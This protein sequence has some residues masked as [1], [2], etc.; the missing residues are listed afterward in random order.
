MLHIILQTVNHEMHTIY[1]VDLTHLYR[2]S[3]SNVGVLIGGLLVIEISS[4]NQM[5]KTGSNVI[6]LVNASTKQLHWKSL[7]QSNEIIRQ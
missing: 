3:F 5:N 4:V 1:C 7:G 2:I 6:L